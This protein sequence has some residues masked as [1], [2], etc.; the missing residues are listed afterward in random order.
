[1]GINQDKKSDVMRFIDYFFVCGLDTNSIKV[2][3]QSSAGFNLLYN[4]I[5]R[6]L[7]AKW[8]FM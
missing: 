1:M 6:H 2:N 5:V 4:I 7:K 8:L 3:N